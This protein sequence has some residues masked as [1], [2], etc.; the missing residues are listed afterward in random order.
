[1]AERHE[2]ISGV[3]DFIQTQAGA[4]PN[5]AAARQETCLRRAGCLPARRAE[6]RRRAP[7]GPGYLY[8]RQRAFLLNATVPALSSPQLHRSWITS[9]CA[10]VCL[11]AAYWA[12]PG[13][14]RRSPAVSPS[15]K[16]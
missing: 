10:A 11:S 2:P 5:A 7:Q 15:T 13:R 12:A 1:V 3:A 14:T 9:A 8:V 6:I 16:R 4:R